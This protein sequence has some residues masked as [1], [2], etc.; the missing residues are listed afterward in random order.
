MNRL[1]KILIRKNKQVDMS[2]SPNNNLKNLCSAIKQDLAAEKKFIKYLPVFF[3]GALIIMF[4]FLHSFG[5]RH[6]LHEKLNQWQMVLTITSLVLMFVCCFGVTK[7]IKSAKSWLIA[8]SFFLLFL[9]FWEPL[10]NTLLGL[11]FAGWGNFA[12]WN[13]AEFGCAVKG[14]TYGMIM[15][16]GLNATQYKL[17]LLPNVQTYFTTGTISA[18]SG[19]MLQNLMCY[20]DVIS[21]LTI[22]HLTQAIGIFALNYVVQK[23]LVIRWKNKL[24]TAQSS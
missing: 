8:S 18:V 10:C 19:I 12:H 24:E 5:L 17:R 14:F 13:P 11:K 9:A 22:N 4:L 16:V 2:K 7:Y 1:S 15:L 3:I 23:F 20:A 21:H 6:D